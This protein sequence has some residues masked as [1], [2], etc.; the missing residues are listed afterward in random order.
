MSY[1]IAPLGGFLVG[2][3]NIEKSWVCML[4]CPKR[5]PANPFGLLKQGPKRG[6]AVRAIS[7]G[8]NHLA[9]PVFS[10]HF[11][12]NWPKRIYARSFTAPQV[13]VSDAVYEVLTRETMKYQAKSKV[14]LKMSAF[15]ESFEISRVENDREKYLYLLGT[16]FMM[17]LKKMK[18]QKFRNRKFHPSDLMI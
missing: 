10:R 6:P 7:R 16:W 1:F 8:R 9:G 2:W 15:S 3:P 14:R 13:S 18:I 11:F 12:T 4:S 17:F 5:G